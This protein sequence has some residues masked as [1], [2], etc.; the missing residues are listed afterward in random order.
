MAPVSFYFGDISLARRFEPWIKYDDNMLWFDP[1]K[2]DDEKRIY[3]VILCDTL[4]MKNYSIIKIS[5]I[6]GISLQSFTDHIWS[7]DRYLK[8]N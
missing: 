3:F 6:L 5:I 8:A 7:Q 2:D 4:Y 1:R